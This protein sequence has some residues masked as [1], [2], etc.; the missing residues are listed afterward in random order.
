[1]G[2]LGLAFMELEADD[3]AEDEARFM[4]EA[5]DEEEV[6]TLVAMAAIAAAA[7]D[8]ANGLRVFLR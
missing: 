8:S 3:V 5:Q 4:A 7:S 2:E 6:A 1:M